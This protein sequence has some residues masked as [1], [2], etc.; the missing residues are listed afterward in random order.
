MA[1]P[2]LKP[3]PVTAD[4]PKPAASTVTRIIDDRRDAVRAQRIPCDVGEREPTKSQLGHTSSDITQPDPAATAATEPAEPVLKA[5]TAT[6]RSNSEF[7]PS[8]TESKTSKQST[9]VAQTQTSTEEQNTTNKTSAPDPT[10][11][12][13]SNV[14]AAGNVGKRLPKPTVPLAQTLAEKKALEVGYPPPRPGG[15]LFT[16]ATS[17]P[18]DDKHED[19]MTMAL[20][21]MTNAEYPST[22]LVI[23]NGAHQTKQ[24]KHKHLTFTTM[25]FGGNFRTAHMYT[26]G[27]KKPFWS[28]PR[29][30][31]GHPKIQKEWAFMPYSR[32]ALPSDASLEEL[33]EEFRQIRAQEAV[34]YQI[35]RSALHSGKSM[36]RSYGVT[37]PKPKSDPL[38]KI[39]RGQSGCA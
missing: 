27:R 11:P 4:A 24:D 8:E 7:A 19:I 5:A 22:H 36:R 16:F 38:S 2:V 33:N 26:C 12:P 13:T 28:D 35:A 25:D 14:A 18:K 6:A 1:N 34:K 39:F 32:T 29:K 15:F 31:K 20:H 23:R 17:P 30:K 3:S 21:F 37:K 9:S 10:S